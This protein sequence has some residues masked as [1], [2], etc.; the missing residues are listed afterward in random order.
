MFLVSSCPLYLDQMAEVGGVRGALIC[1][2][3]GFLTSLLCLSHT[4][5]I[6]PVSLPCSIFPQCLISNCVSISYTVFSCR[7]YPTPLAM[8]SE[9]PCF[10]WKGCISYGKFGGSDIVCLAPCSL[11]IFECYNVGLKHTLLCALGS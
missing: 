3:S 10:P 2:R 6:D 9:S 5:I 7:T 4:T 8:A 1:R 11:Y